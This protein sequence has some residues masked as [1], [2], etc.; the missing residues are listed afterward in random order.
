MYT[1]LKSLAKVLIHNYLKVLPIYVNDYWLYINP[2]LY[3]LTPKMFIGIYD[4]YEIE[5]FK[6]L[7]K[8]GW[9]VCDIGAA[10]GYYS[11]IASNKVGNT[12]KVYAFEPDPYTFKLLQK[13]IRLYNLKNVYPEQIAIADKKGA[14]AFYQSETHPW[15]NRL[16][17]P[18]DQKRKKIYIRQD[19]LDNLLKGI[20]RVDLV[21]MDVQGVEERCLDGMTK[22]INSNKKIILYIELWPR[23]LKEAGSNTKRFLDK[24]TGLGFKIYV[25][26][27]IEKRVVLFKNLDELLNLV[28][29]LGYVDIIC[30]R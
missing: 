3:W 17:N 5:V 9:V 24:L 18:P 30:K 29:W 1:Y 6:K 21:K 4:T 27:T 25:L 26:N 23:G 8:E 15:D 11:I 20:R 10:V 22:I 12:G 19:T 13:N 14:V 16:I 2:S 28:N 7:V